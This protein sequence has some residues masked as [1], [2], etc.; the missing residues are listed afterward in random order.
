VACLICDESFDTDLLNHIRLMHPYILDQR[1]ETE[2]LTLKRVT[3]EM[4]DDD[5][6]CEKCDQQFRTG[7]L[8]GESFEGMF[9]GMPV[10][11]LI[12]GGCF[13]GGV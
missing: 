5:Q 1:T 8:F 6:V 2:V 7:M 12:C 4:N 9:H 10:V 3:Q 11:S 13:I